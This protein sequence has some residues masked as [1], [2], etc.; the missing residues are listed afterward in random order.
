MNRLALTLLISACSLSAANAAV[1]SHD[2]KT[3]GDGLLTYDDVNQREWL[4]LTQTSLAQF[5]GANRE[6][7]YQYVATQILPGGIFTGF[8]IAKSADLTQL[9]IS[10]GIDPNST[11]FA[12]NALPTMELGLLLPF[13]SQFPNG[14]KI[15]AGLIDE[16]ITQPVSVRLGAMFV[17]GAVTGPVD[18]AGLLNRVI[19]DRLNSPLPGVFMFRQAV[20][21]PGGEL[22]SLF[23]LVAFSSLH[24]HAFGRR[25]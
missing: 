25:I 10:A 2:W 11:S 22:L 1:I 9:A 17:I 5:P 12:T 6:A 20:P 8:Q 19:D 13:T 3:P 14:S 16:F 15:A 18:E 4:D 23:T 7:K 24:G 21:E